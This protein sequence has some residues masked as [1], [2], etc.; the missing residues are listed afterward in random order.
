MLF[1]IILFVAC[2]AQTIVL[3]MGRLIQ[4]CGAGAC[5]ALWRSIFRDT[6]EGAE[7]AKYGS[8]FS[9]LVTFIVPAAPLFGGYLQ[10]YF[11]WRASFAFLAIYS[12]S[13]LFTKFSS[14]RANITV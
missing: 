5:S 3:I 6:F 10:E 4:G 9:I 13:T 2:S 1:P 11:N 8:Y 14:L 7:L 12:L